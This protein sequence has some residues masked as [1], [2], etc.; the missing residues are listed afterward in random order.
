MYLDKRL[1]DFLD[2]LASSQST[3]GGGS[4]SAL[5]GAVGAGLASMVAQLTQGKAEYAPVEQEIEA[6]LQ[7]TEALRIRFQQLMQEDIGA[8]ERLSACFKIPKET[9]EER[10]A[11]TRAI[12]HRLIE[13]AL[14]P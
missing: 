2:D 10:V 3:P 6:L 8:Y 4:A 13:A 11:R 9:N 14:V 5:A 7:H 12:Q 1:N